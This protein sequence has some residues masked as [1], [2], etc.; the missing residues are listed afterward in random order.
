MGDVY[1][2]DD[3][4]LGR[5]VAIKTLP[6]SIA[7]DPDRVLRF[8]R[9]ARLLASLLHTHIAAVL[10]FEEASSPPDGHTIRYLVLEHIEGPTLEQR[11][12]AGP[13][14]LREALTIALQIALALE[15]AHDAGVVHRDLKPANIK[16][17]SDD[18]LKVLDFGLA[19]ALAREAEP[20]ENSPTLI[21]GATGAG[22]LLGT[23]AYMSPEQARGR[24]VDQRSDLWSF[25][26]VL[27]E[28]L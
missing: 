12:A 28:M 1:L 7:A 25:G 3:T 8:E 24:S 2:A 10:G 16:F 26:C 23:A 13:L 20:Q 17:K 21:A 15:A 27:Y 6:A 11:L 4:S 18:T 9:E 14:P 22:M 5:V 19:K